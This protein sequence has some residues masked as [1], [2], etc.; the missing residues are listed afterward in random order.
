MKKPR[1]PLFYGILVSFIGLSVW[2]VFHFPFDRLALYSA[3]PPNAVFIGEHEK[4]AERWQVVA[5]NPLSLCLL[6]SAGLSDKDVEKAVN[7]V[8]VDR[9]LRRFASRD[10]IIA[11][12]PSL[13]Q[14]GQPAWV[15]S[16]WAGSHAQLMRFV[17]ACG[18]L[19]GFKK[20]PLDDGRQVWCTTVGKENSKMTVSLAVE[21]GILLG[22]VSSDSSAVR[23]I[24]DRVEESAPLQTD[25]ARRL[26]L[27]AKENMQPGVQDRGWLDL[28]W[29]SGRSG[30]GKVR[31]ALSG[32]TEHG[33]M[34]WVRGTVP[35]PASPCL[36]DS[37]DFNEL[38]DLLG[39]APDALVL[40]PISYLEHVLSTNTTHGAWRIAAQF[41][42]AEAADKGAIFGAFLGGIY[43]GRIL[44]L[45]VPT[46]MM[47][48]K[49]RDPNTVLDRVAAATDRLNSECQVGL[50]PARTEIQRHS[51]AV[52]GLN[53]DNIFASLKPEE[54]PAFVVAGHHLVLSSNTG[55]AEKVLAGDSTIPEAGD[56]KGN[57]RWLKGLGGGGGNATAYAWID[58][59]AANQALKN[60]VAVYTLSLLVRSSEGRIENRDQLKNLS[61]WIDALRLLKTC[62]L[63][64]TSDSEGFDLQFEFG[65]PP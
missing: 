34:G 41:L 35:F 19:P 45:K 8:R 52:L 61:G 56:Q 42:A 4:I 6:K 1:R 26:D 17:L 25:L 55:A 59:E 51:A 43:S 62:R 40:M 36:R 22:C 20:V 60:A 65:P 18:V 28:A 63:W 16:S 7:D 15:V 21:Q 33:S 10:T 54:R 5:K 2:W 23:Y 31:Y 3:I 13:G 46:V 24:A 37:V 38:K 50:V 64:L 39:D 30:A 58:L 49:V 48:M 9:N 47:G 57:A 12:V 32:H 14:S 11:Y 53:R 29:V 27:E 44:G